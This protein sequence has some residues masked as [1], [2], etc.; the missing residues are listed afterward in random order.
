IRY[1]KNLSLEDRIRRFHVGDIREIDDFPMLWTWFE[2]DDVLES[3]GHPRL[4]STADGFFLQRYFWDVLIE[5]IGLEY[6]KLLRDDPAPDQPRTTLIEFS[7]GAQHGG[8]AS[9][10]EHLSQP[11]LASSAIV[12]VNVSWEESLRKNRR[13]F[14]PQRPDSILEHALPDRKL[15][16]LYR[17]TDWFELTAPDPHT[18]AIQGKNVPYVVFENDDDV[19]SGENPALGLRLEQALESLWQRYRA[20]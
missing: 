20:A 9:A 13:R 4:H 8:Y 7:R 11:I 2:E 5:R 14:N 18:I 1:L 19:T 10:F 6:D 12:Y 17:E 3:M 16:Y 15:E